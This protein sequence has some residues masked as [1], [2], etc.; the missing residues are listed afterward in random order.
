MIDGD[1]QRGFSPE[2]IVSETS[3]SDSSDPTKQ[4]QNVNETI[5][6]NE[7]VSLSIGA[8]LE[9][10]DEGINPRN[11]TSK[12]GCQM[13]YRDELS[14]PSAPN[15][16]RVKVFP[17]TGIDGFVCVNTIKKRTQILGLMGIC[18]LRR[19]SSTG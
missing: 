12:K 18:S 4:I 8:R 19:G 1:A 15:I 13:S 16:R 14:I 10:R 2:L 3:G 7:A 5:R 6:M 17:Q 11:P 9:T